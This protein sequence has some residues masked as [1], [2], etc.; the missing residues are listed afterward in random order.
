MV[1][2][3]VQFCLNTPE[4]AKQGVEATSYFTYYTYSIWKMP[5]CRATFISFYAT[6]QLKVKGSSS[7]STADLGFEPTTF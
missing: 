7:G 6:D 1:G 4:Y 2:E 5:K 3:C